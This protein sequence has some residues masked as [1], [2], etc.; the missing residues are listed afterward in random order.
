MILRGNFVN[1]Q[2]FWNC[3]RSLLPDDCQVPL[4]GVSTSAGIESSTTVNGSIVSASSFSSR[5]ASASEGASTGPEIRTSKVR[6][7]SPPGR[8]NRLISASARSQFGISANEFVF[9]LIGNDWKK[10]GLDTLLEAFALCGDLPARLL[11]VGTDSQENYSKQTQTLQLG[12]RVSF[13]VP[14]KDV[15]QFYAAADAYVGP[16]L[17]D[18]YGLPILESMACGLPVI[19]SL[20]AGASDFENDPRWIT[21]PGS[22]A[23]NAGGAS[24][25]SHKRSA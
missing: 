1:G 24:T 13:L 23:Y 22:S 21:Q 9:L 8:S 18:A 17:E 15:L 7:N 10:K 14:S 6:M 3:A 20:N 16:S 4:C 12:S 25:P 5:L 2:N 19:A 11:V